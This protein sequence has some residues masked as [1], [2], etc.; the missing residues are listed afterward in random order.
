MTTNQPKLITIS[1]IEDQRE[2]R[3]SLAECLGN[4]P[5]LRCVGAHASGDERYRPLC[6]KAVA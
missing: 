5:G 4:V 6:R 1:I 3:E 2:M